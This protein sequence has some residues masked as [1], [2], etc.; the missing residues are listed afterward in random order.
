MTPFWRGVRRGAGQGAI[1]GGFGGALW[2][3]FWPG[4][5]TPLSQAVGILGCTICAL[6]GILI[7]QQEGNK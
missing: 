1:V 5:A 7:L 6:L 4:E 2:L 3:T